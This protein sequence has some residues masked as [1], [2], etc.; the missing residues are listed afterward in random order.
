ML[1]T[2]HIDRPLSYPAPGAD[3]ASPGVAS[4][5]APAVER[6]G[7][8]GAL[9]PSGRYSLPAL[10]DVTG[11][12]ARSRKWT[13]LLPFG[14][15]AAQRLLLSNR[16]GSILRHRKRIRPLHPAHGRS[17]QQQPRQLARVSL[18]AVG[19]TSLVGLGGGAGPDTVHSASAALIGAFRSHGRTRV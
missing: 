17:T 8:T 7:G 6:R 2:G 19:A 16:E 5:S 11:G 15:R 4:R 9:S 13:P 12:V 14:P 10:L 18:V 1:V 3:I